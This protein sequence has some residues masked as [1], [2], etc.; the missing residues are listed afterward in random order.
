MRRASALALITLS[1]CSQGSTGDDGGVDLAAHT[2]GVDLAASTDAAVDLAVSTDADVDLRASDDLSYQP[3]D[4][5]WPFGDL[6][7]SGS[8][9]LHEYACP[10]ELQNPRCLTPFPSPG[11]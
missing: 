4:M 3:S 6:S 11:F 1:A 7:A 10:P 9:G 2:E 8:L 5:A